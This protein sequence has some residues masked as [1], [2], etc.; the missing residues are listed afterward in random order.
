MQRQDLWYKEEQKAMGLIPTASKTGQFMVLSAQT[1]VDLETGKIV[2]DLRGLPPEVSTMLCPFVQHLTSANYGPTMAQTW[3]IYQN[4]SK[5]LAKEGASLKDIVRQRIYLRDVKAVAWMEEV[6]LRF[7]PDEKPATLFLGIADKGLHPDIHVWVEAMVLIPQK[8]GLVKEAIYVP[9]LQKVTG[10]YPQ[11]VKVGQFLFFEGMAGVD[12]NTGLPVTS[13]NEIGGEGRNGAEGLFIDSAFE[14]TKVQYW[15]AHMHIKRLLESQGAG[16]NDIL[17]TYTFRKQGVVMISETE[18]IRD[19]IYDSVEDSPTSEGFCMYN[20]SIIPDLEILTGGVALLPGEYKK[21]AGKCS[22]ADREGTFAGMTQAG[23]FWYQAGAIP[24]DLANE[25]HIMNF[26]ECPDDGR[27]LA[28]GRVDFS[29]LTMAKAWYIYQYLLK[30]IDTSQVMEQTI[31]LTNTAELSAVE[32]V[33][34]IIF[35]GN[36]PPTTVIPCDDIAFYF[37]THMSVPK[38]V[39]GQHIEISMWGLTS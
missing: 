10:P 11:A 32:R 26:S 25:K 30:G 4:L 29:Q 37:P 39:G 33:S 20:M 17:Q 13:F 12:L 23:P 9:E 1:G 2:Q 16:I 8:G 15:L 38:S 22:D 28:Q 18:Y 19:R 31:Y 35:K 27:F 7:F 3:T 21:E 14:T 34:S 36:M 6:M 5:I 24:T